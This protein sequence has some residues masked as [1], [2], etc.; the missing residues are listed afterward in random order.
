MENRVE[1]SFDANVFSY[2]L[3]DKL[4]TRMIVQLRE[5]SGT[6]GQEII[7]RD[8]FVAACDEMVAQV[9]ADKTR[10]AGNEDSH[11]R[12]NLRKQ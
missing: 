9:R 7:N 6:A 3:P 10:T 11:W 5:V 12:L 4:E 2:V 1:I 8:N